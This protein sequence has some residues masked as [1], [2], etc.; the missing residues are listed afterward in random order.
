MPTKINGSS[1]GNLKAW[2]IKIPK[3]DA[4]QDLRQRG[5]LMSEEE[6]QLDEWV[7]LHRPKVLRRVEQASPE[8]LREVAKL[9][10]YKEE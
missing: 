8:V 5:F 9:I 1:E 3:K 7:H 6:V 10:G 4:D 2:G